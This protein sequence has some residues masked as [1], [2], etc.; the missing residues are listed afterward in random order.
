MAQKSELEKLEQRYRENPS[1]WFA[2]LADSYRKAGELELALEVVQSGIIDRPDYPSAQIVLARVL[3]DMDRDREAAQAFQ[4]V[5]SLDAENIIALKNLSE[6]AERQGDIPM[7]QAWLRRLLEVDPMNEEAESALTR[8]GPV[9]DVAV[10]LPVGPDGDAH[11]FIDPSELEPL[12]SETD[13]IPEATHDAAGVAARDEGHLEP[14]A[15]SEDDSTEAPEVYERSH[16]FSAPEPVAADETPLPNDED[17]FEVEAEADASQGVGASELDGVASVEDLVESAADAVADVGAED[18][19]RVEADLSMDFEVDEPEPLLETPRT[20]EAVDDLLVMQDLDTS[21][22]LP[23][24]G[25]KEPVEFDFDL[26]DIFQEEEPLVEPQQ[27]SRAEP[28]PLLDPMAA[29]LTGIEVELDALAADAGV[30]AGDDLGGDRDSTER[31]EEPE[32]SSAFDAEPKVPTDLPDLALEAVGEDDDGSSS[33]DAEQAAVSVGDSSEDEPVGV[34]PGDHEPVTVAD[35]SAAPPYREPDYTELAEAAEP[36]EL[37]A[38]L[39]EPE[40]SPEPSI[41]DPSERIRVDKAGEPEPVVTGTMA[42]VYAQQGLHREA[43][44]IYEQLLDRHPEDHDLQE[45]LEALRRR[46]PVPSAVDTVVP[47][48]MSRFSVAHTGGVPAK[49]VLRQIFSSRL[50][51]ASRGDESVSPSSV[52]GMSS[53]TDDERFEDAPERWHEG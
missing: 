9:R 3:L 46:Q 13:E 49:V 37:S 25:R 5:L 19:E 11:A 7:A 27:A 48:R 39:A 8:L 32:V 21:A 18:V 41:E 24:S 50:G 42:E 30:E 36:V 1:Q 47:K 52:D 29:E 20:S 22:L 53:D 6:L 16:E 34:P 15:P 2:A 35:D 45:K 10:H 33:D 4:R 14:S 28:A 12:P 23:S 17:V 44:E 43:L 31:V 40:V 26:E 51:T 38:D